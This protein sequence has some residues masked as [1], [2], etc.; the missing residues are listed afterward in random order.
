MRSVTSP[1]SQGVRV[2]DRQHLRSRK[3]KLCSAAFSGHSVLLAGGGPL[4]CLRRLKSARS[5]VSCNSSGALRPNRCVQ[6]DQAALSVSAV[7]P[8]QRRP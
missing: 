6:T 7:V 3:V 1:V 2:C 5:E 4:S 8:H